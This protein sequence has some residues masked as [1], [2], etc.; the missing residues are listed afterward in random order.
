[1]SLSDPQ[2]SAVRAAILA[3]PELAALPI[4]PD[5]A[6]TVADA[7]DAASSPPVL[8]W[9]TD[10]RVVDVHDAIDYD[11]Y[12]PNA[13]ADGTAAY[14]NRIL[15]VQT[16]QMNLQNMLIGRET[17]N[18]GLARLR[19]SLLDAVTNLPTGAN[20]SL[21]SAGGAG[22]ARVM[23]AL[24]RVATRAEALLS[25]TEVTTGTVTARSLAFEGELSY[26]DVLS[27]LAHG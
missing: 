5:N 6:Q 13:A 17:V 21:R 9:R 18:A 4:T 14:T 11:Q 24:T 19:S 23:A 7:L 10:A 27:A 1:M 16:K 8:A 12:T 2:L 15:L 22:G 3:D 20:G 26:M 25:P